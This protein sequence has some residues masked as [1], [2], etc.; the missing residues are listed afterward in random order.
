MIVVSVAGIGNNV[1]K[2]VD[3]TSTLATTSLMFYQKTDK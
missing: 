1:D 3:G 2:C